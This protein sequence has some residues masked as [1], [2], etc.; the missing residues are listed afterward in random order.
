VDVAHDCGDRLVV[1]RNLPLALLQSPCVIG[2]GKRAH[3]HTHRHRHRHRHMDTHIQTH[4]PTHTHTQYPL[5]HNT[6]S[7]T[8]THT[9]THAGTHGRTHAHTHT[10]TLT[11]SHAHQH[12]L[13]ITLPRT[14]SLAHTLPASSDGLEPLRSIV[15]AHLGGDAVA[16]RI[17]AERRVAH[18]LRRPTKHTN[19]GADNKQKR[20]NNAARR[21]LALFGTSLLRALA[22]TRAH[23]RTHARQCMR[24]CAAVLRVCSLWSSRHRLDRALERGEPDFVHHEWQQQLARDC[25]NSFSHAR[26]QCVRYEM[27]PPVGPGADVGGEPTWSRRECPRAT[28]VSP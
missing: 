11:H 13:T 12:A 26:P 6:H 8:D 5:S 14:H 3:S 23:A 15:A 25:E 10:H 28:G 7:H 27:T 1:Q 17:G 24:V 16:L 2:A 9:D 22:R 18:H 4:R 21:Q 19:K 20:D